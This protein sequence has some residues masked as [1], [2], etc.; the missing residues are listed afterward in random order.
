VEIELG[1]VEHPAVNGD[2]CNLRK[3]Q[4][5]NRKNGKIFKK[6][7]ADR[8]WRQLFEEW[9]KRILGHDIN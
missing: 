4:P 1:R 5:L 2:K 3:S 8:V 9:N 6:R 7:H